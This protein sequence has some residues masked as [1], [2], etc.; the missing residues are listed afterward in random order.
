VA[1]SDGRGNKRDLVTPCM[2]ERRL[3]LFPEGK[4]QL[5]CGFIDGRRALFLGEKAK[6]RVA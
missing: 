3:M 1:T 2:T 6:H 4:A 5:A